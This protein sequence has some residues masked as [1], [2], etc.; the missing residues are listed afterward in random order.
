MNPTQITTTPMIN[1]QPVIGSNNT[2]KIPNPKPIK[3]MAS[4]FLNNFIIPLLPPLFLYII[5]IFFIIGS[6]LCRIRKCC[7]TRKALTNSLLSY[8]IQI[9]NVI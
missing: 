9:E 2:N 5:L 8:K 7:T 4:V 6:F 1:S 3:Q